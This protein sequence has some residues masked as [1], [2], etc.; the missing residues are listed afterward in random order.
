[1]L[2]FSGS[3]SGDPAAVRGLTLLHL[4]RGLL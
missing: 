1:L 2:A 3:G 4:G